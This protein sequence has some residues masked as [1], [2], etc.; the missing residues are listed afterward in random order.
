MDKIC[1]ICELPLENDEK[2][3]IWCGCATNNSTDTD[4]HLIKKLD[5]FHSFQNGKNITTLNN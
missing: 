2:Y 1:S 5:Y 3:C 4:K